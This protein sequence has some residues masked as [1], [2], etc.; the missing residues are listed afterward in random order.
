VVFYDSA[1]PNGVLYF[2]PV[3]PA[4]QF[5]LH[6][7]TKAALPSVTALSSDLLL[8]AEYA[9]ALTYSL[10]VRIAMQNGISPPPGIVATMQQALSVIRMANVQIPEARVPTFSRFGG[11]IAASSDPGFMGGWSS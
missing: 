3:P 9:E 7:S 2:W 11:G 4:G 5:E 8:P 6:I 10:A 1:F